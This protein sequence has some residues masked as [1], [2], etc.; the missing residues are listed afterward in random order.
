M[1][2]LYL[3]IATFIFISCG[4]ADTPEAL[5]PKPKKGNQT[6]QYNKLTAEE[7]YI[8]EQKG[9]ERAFTGEYHDHKASGTY[10]CRKCNAPLYKSEDKFDSRCGWPSFDD[11][12]KDAVI[13]KVDAD[14]RRT[15]IL[16]AN[17]DGHLGHVFLGEG[18]TNKNTRHCVNSL[19]MKFIAEGQELPKATPPIVK[20][21]AIFASGCF[22]GTEYWLQRFPGV[23]EAT[24]GYIGGHVKNPTYQEVCTGTTGH[25]EAVE[26]IYDANQADFESIAKLYFETHNP[27]QKN[28]QG[29][30]IGSQY[31]PAIFYLDE[32]QRETTEKLLQILRDKGLNPATE[33]KPATKFYPAEGYHQDYYFRKGSKPYCH[34]YK[35]LF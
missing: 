7:A 5:K 23:I 31:L 32:E 22:W 25:Y 29:P 20:K 16:C 18:F 27:E 17:C 26:V 2:K 4:Q 14:G 33:V 19:S 3:L 34:L 12:I 28:G 8:I 11:E 1:Y 24:S 30:D 15:E 21:K 10:I 35:K 9:T 6:V 13:R